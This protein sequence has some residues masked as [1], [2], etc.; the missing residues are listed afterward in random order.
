MHAR[1][2]LHD[3]SRNFKETTGGEKVE[4]FACWLCERPGLTAGEQT[5][6]SSSRAVEKQIKAGFGPLDVPSVRPFAERE[7]KLG[8]CQGG[9]EEKEED[10]QTETI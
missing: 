9:G 4:N 1:K 3:K 6:Y 2:K 8:S 10:R 7:T 5:V